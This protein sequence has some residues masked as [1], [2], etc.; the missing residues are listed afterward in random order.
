M[1]IPIFY[2]GLSFHSGLVP[3]NASAKKGN[4]AK[5]GRKNTICL[6]VKPVCFVRGEKFIADIKSIYILYFLNI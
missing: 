2:N 6:G 3:V 5:C 1:G 4:I